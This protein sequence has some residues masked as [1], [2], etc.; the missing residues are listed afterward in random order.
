MRSFEEFAAEVEGAAGA[1]VLVEDAEVGDPFLAGGLFGGGDGVGVGLG[2]YE[3]GWTLVP[4]I[5]RCLLLT[6]S[7]IREVRSRG[8]H[9]IKVWLRILE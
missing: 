2:V 5:M 7:T 6:S 9:A 8:R 1:A 3:T 4:V